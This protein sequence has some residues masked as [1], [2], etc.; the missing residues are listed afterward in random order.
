MTSAINPITPPGVY[1]ADPEAHVAPDGKMYVYG[2]NDEKP[3]QWC[4]HVHHVLSS[5]DLIHWNI[6]Y[7]V[8]ASKGD[9]DQVAEHDR[10]LYA[11]DCAYKDGRY[12][13]YYCSPG[14]DDLTAGVA[15]SDTPYGPFINGMSIKGVRQID[16]AVLVDG[17]DVYY[18]WGQCQPKV[19]KL[20]PDMLSIDPSTIQE[21]LKGE[22]K[23][24][25]FHE[26]SSIRKIGDTYYFVYAD[27]SRRGR[28]TCLGYATSKSPMGPF[29]YKGVI[30][31]NFGCDPASWNNH[32]SIEQFKGK[33]YIFYHRTTN[34]TS[35]LRKVCIEP[36]TINPD[37]SIG[38]VE[39]TSQGAGPAL[40]AFS[41]I[42]AEWACGLTGKTI[43]SDSDTIG[44]LSK[45][46]AGSSACYRYIDFGT[47]AT[48]LNVKLTG[49]SNGGRICVCIDSP[50]TKPIAVCDVPAER[51][52]PF[53]VLSCEVEKVE[54]THSL[55]LRF[56]GKGDNLYEVD[57]FTFTAK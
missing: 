27:E 45:I 8:F 49:P 15:V 48:M 31:D 43:I 7:N 17:D 28:P 52:G 12:Y 32:G 25:F 4:S 53:K 16:P 37:G 21:C 3:E 20:N 18:Y 33:W 57:W 23:D 44:K 42:E 51:N 34:G 29:E 14:D 19:A 38:E 41:R 30:I 26:G 13:L 11:P 24:N 40:D 6:D 39:M 47:G 36:I 54:G 9:N 35:S 56:E 2:S 55:Y 50:E 5:T 1:I 10:L 46:D 22:R